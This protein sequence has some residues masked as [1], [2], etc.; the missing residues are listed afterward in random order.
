MSFQLFSKVC[1]VGHGTDVLR[2]IE[3]MRSALRDRRARR[4]AR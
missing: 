1:G 3:A 4:H 2:Q